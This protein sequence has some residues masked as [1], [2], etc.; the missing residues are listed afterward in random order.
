M[1][2]YIYGVR[3]AHTMKSVFLKYGFD[4]LQKDERV[5]CQTAKGLELGT[6]T[7]L[8]IINSNININLLETIERRATE[9][10]VADDIKN[11]EEAKQA[12]KVFE[13]ESLVL[14]LDMHLISAYYTLNKDKLVF[15]YMASERV[16]FRE[17][18]KVMAREFHTR[19]DLRQINTRDR[20]QFIGGIGVCGLALCCTTYL[21]DFE[22]INV[23]KAKNQMLTINSSKI[24]GQCG[25]LLCCLKH[26]DETYTIERKEFPQIGDSVKI[27]GINYK[28]IGYNIIKREVRLEGPEGHEN[29]TLDEVLGR[30]PKKP[31][32]EPITRPIVRQE[33]EEKNNTEANKTGEG[34]KRRHRFFKKKNKHE[35]NKNVQS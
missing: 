5:V 8:A 4:N 22:G 16:D 14:N 26:E 18:L 21:T 12:I 17:F 2:N 33:H 32:E 20:A 28:V 25:K 9:K 27:R 31:I 15:S 23:Q 7:T 34:K 30:A 19:I 13:R 1:E 6:I 35:K 10:D 11:M 24:N 3:F 29:K